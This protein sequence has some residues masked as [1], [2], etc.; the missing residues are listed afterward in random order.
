MPK[1]YFSD[2][3]IMYHKF[4]LGWEF[5]DIRKIWFLVRK[6]PFVEPDFQEG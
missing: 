3:L 2:S 5:G 4:H 6:R 1:K